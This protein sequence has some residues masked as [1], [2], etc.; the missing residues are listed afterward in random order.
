MF[1]SKG[2][3]LGIAVTVVTSVL[4]VAGMGITGTAGAG[5]DLPGTI[6]GGP[7][8]PL[9]TGAPPQSPIEPPAVTT[10]PGAAATDGTTPGTT[11]ATTNENTGGQAGV[12]NGPNA[13]PDAGFG[14]AQ[15]GSSF[16][17]MLILIGMAGAV[18]VG[19]GATAIGASRRK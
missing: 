9:T 11:P 5:T 18:L 2:A 1:K 13:L 4:L 16:S 17:T 19:A 3:V 6:G 15:G 7:G 14:Q 12:N 10:N 8:Y